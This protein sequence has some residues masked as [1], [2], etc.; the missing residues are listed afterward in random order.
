MHT[1]KTMIYLEPDM[2]EQLRLLAFD[3]RV[4][5]AELIRRAVADYLKT[6]RPTRK[7]GGK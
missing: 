4:S 5:I 3:G 1:R 2:H 7:R 6:H